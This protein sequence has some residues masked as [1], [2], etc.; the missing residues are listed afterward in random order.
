MDVMNH[1]MELT[2]EEVTE[3]VVVPTE[4]SF[5]RQKFLS[6]TPFSR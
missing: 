1:N 5:S 6:S 3:D 4:E 2:P